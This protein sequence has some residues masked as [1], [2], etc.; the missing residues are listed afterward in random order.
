MNKNFLSNNARGTYSAPQCEVLRVQGEGICVSGS[1]ESGTVT[2][3]GESDGIEQ[4]I[5]IESIGTLF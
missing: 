5:D 1:I 4:I 2:E 3:W